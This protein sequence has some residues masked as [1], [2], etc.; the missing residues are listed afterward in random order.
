[1][2]AEIPDVVRQLFETS[3]LGGVSWQMVVMWVLAVVLCS[4]GPPTSSTR[5]P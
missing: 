5:P 1:M 2:S 4:F 3:G